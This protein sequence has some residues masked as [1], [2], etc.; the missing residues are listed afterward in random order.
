MTNLVLNF[1]FAWLSVFC[2]ILLCLKFVTR[3]LR[4][5]KANKFLR[6]IHIPVGILLILFS[7]L[8]SL[9]SSEALLSINFGTATFAI[10]ILLALT[11]IC[12]KKLKKMWFFLH[13]LL[14]VAMVGLLITH[15]ITVGGIQV[16]N[17]LFPSVDIIEIDNTNTTSSILTTVEPTQQATT[18]ATSET[19]TETSTTQEIEESTIKEINNLF[20][21]YKLN[22]GTYQGSGTGFRG[23][24][25]V[26]ITVSD[27]AVKDINLLQINDD[28]KFYERAISTLYNEIINGQTTNVDAV[29]R[30][31]YSSNGYIEA[32]KNAVENAAAN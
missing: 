1:L 26:E 18:E 24:L 12:R 19:T 25:T 21:G 6:S 13:R 3:K 20:D 27:G 7:F 15:I 5:H 10:S 4:W 17:V 16:F 32:V 9:F 31:T 29:S 23:T 8:H 14:T 30:A 2:M 11:Y 28:A 22:D